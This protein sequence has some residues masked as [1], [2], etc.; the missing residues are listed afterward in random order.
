MPCRELRLLWHSRLRRARPIGHGRSLRP[1]QRSTGGDRRQ[2]AWL[3]PR[4]QRGDGDHQ[5]GAR[6]RSSSSHRRRMSGQREG[7]ALVESDHLSLS[8][9]Y[10]VNR[11][12]PRSP[13]VLPV[14]PRPVSRFGAL[15]ACGESHP[16]CS[17]SFSLSRHFRH[18]LLFPEGAT[19]PDRFGPSLAMIDMIDMIDQPVRLTSSSDGSTVRVRSVLVRSSPGTSR[20]LCSM[21]SDDTP[22]GVAS[23]PR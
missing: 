3:H 2:D 7:S 12:P 13:P 17:F 20:L 6:E 22:E 5:R 4:D 19:P 15:S 10:G 11:S 23:C 16:G 1:D 9:S 14:V 8:T 18:R 21:A